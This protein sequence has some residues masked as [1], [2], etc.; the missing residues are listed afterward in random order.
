[1]H[2]HYTHR[3]VT[4][5][6]RHRPWWLEVSLCLRFLHGV[7]PVAT[8]LAFLR[9]TWGTRHCGHAHSRPTLYDRAQVCLDPATLAYRCGHIPLADIGS[10][11]TA[12]N[13]QPVRTQAVRGDKLCSGSPVSTSLLCGAYNCWPALRLVSLEALVP[14]QSREI[15]IMP[16]VSL[17][18][19]GASRM[20]RRLCMA[21]RD[22]VVPESSI[23]AL[24]ASRSSWQHGWSVSGCSAAP[25]GRLRMVP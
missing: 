7:L 18:T 15:G 12:A 6:R 24:R 8:A 13:A 9:S 10:C 1:M 21:M 3:A 22:A 25:R 20:A 5:T 19:W 23:G 14:E 17:T 16:R 4:V 11:Y 2:R